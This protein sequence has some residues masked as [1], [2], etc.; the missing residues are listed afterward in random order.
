M[1]RV[2]FEQSREQ[3]VTGDVPPSRRATSLIGSTRVPPSGTLPAP[4]PSARASPTC[5]GYPRPRLCCYPCSHRTPRETPQTTTCKL[6]G[7]HRLNDASACCASLRAKIAGGRQGQQAG[8]R[9]SLCFIKSVLCWLPLIP[10]DSAKISSSGVPASSTR[11]AR[12]QVGCGG[13]TH[14]SSY[15]FAQA[16]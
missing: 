11:H 14:R 2:S 6:R 9:V 8:R 5:L 1:N 16:M 10:G 4:L 3:S 13:R 7:H 15:T 12:A